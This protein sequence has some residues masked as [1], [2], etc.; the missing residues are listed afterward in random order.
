MTR[1]TG[2]NPNTMNVVVDAVIAFKRIA[3][4]LIGFDAHCRGMWG[5]LVPI[6][7]YALPFGYEPDAVFQRN[8]VLKFG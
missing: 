6:Q 1:A 4:A 3:M 7:S 2:F 5:G 8:M